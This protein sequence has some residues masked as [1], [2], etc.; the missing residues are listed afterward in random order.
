MLLLS[1]ISHIVQMRHIQRAEC[2]I[3]RCLIGGPEVAVYII[4]AQP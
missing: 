2:K 4:L 1:I 3:I